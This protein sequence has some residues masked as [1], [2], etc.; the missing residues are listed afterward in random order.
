MPDIATSSSVVTLSPPVL[1]ALLRACF[2]D[3]GLPVEDAAAVADVLVDAD[4][5]GIE[6]HG[7]NR[8]PVYLER[9]AAG[10]VG[11][12]NEMR[13]VADTGAIVRIDA[14]RS[15]GPAAAV[16]AMRCAIQR[17]RSHGIGLVTVGRSSHFGHAGYYARM[18]ARESLIGIIMSNAARSMAP[19]GGA[20]AFLGANPLA[21]AVPLHH[22]QE[23]VLDMSTSVVARGSIRRCAILGES[24]E[25]GQAI[26]AEGNATRDPEAA[27]GGAVLPTGGP[28]GSGLATAITLVLGLLAGADFDHEV[29]SMYEDSPP[30]NI[31]HLFLVI[32]PGNVAG[33]DDWPA[34][35]RSFVDSFHAVAP[36]TPGQPV[37]LAG[38]HQARLA[39]ERQSSVPVSRTELELLAETV[40]RLG[41][42]ERATE[43]ELLLD[44]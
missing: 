20:E 11:G 19:H 13:V 42:D 36:A 17:A 6:S 34:R 1:H 14:G 16:S 25:P 26:D 43:I 35:A 2:A 41:M 31:G 40:A 3:G 7:L 28:K 33:D 44:R 22:G 24:L 12:S 32:D 21:I 8:A 37:E 4:L 23:F 15:I 30:Q 38:E 10:M 18:A 27:L 5:R 29:E 9:I 39:A